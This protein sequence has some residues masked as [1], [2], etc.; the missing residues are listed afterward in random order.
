MTR[1][2]L[3]E[4]PSTQDIS[5]DAQG[6]LAQSERNAQSIERGKLVDFDF[7]DP[8]ANDNAE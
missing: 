6:I 2:R 3:Y 5:L 8:T 4:T 7:D 1:K